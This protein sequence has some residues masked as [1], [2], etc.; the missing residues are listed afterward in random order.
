MEYTYRYTS[1]LGE[2]TLKS[3][4]TA[5]TGLSFDL[6]QPEDAPSAAP[7]E[8]LLPVFT[9]TKR[10]LD[11]Y[12]GGGVPDFTPPLHPEGTAFRR[13]VWDELR[14]VPYGQTASYGE[15][16]KRLAAQGRKT[17]ARA[18]GGAAHNNPI[19]LI[20]PCHRIVGADGSLT[21]YAAGLE[22]KRK[23]LALEQQT[24]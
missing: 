3:D 24:K 16:A 13:A 6:Q 12:F 20:V 14:K 7:K 11:T 18:V 22:R 19:A 2:I 23:L 17:C 4:G 8:T 9:Q 15:I 1:P 10:W 5:L 21:G